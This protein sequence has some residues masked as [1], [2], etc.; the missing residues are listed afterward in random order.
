MDRHIIQDIKNGYAEKEIFKK[1]ISIWIYSFEFGIHIELTSANV[2][3]EC[4]EMD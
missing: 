2:K 3:F 4:Y 1:F